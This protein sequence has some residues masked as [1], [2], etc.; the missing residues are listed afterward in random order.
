MPKSQ[1]PS[2]APNT[3]KAALSHQQVSC[4]SAAVPL[5]NLGVAFNGLWDN[6][7]QSSSA[8]RRLSLWGRRG[9]QS[10]RTELILT[11]LGVAK[12]FF[13]SS[14]RPCSSCVQQ[15]NPLWKWIDWVCS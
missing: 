1:I 8:E 10:K 4:P 3:E 12:P 14:V 7:L 9:I 15:Q 13:I 2:F 11:G 6:P 5:A